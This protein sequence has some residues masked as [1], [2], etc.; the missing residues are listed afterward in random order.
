V[1]EGES[2]LR[3]KPIPL[4]PGQYFDAETGLHQNWNRDHDPAIG[5]YLQSDPIGLDAGLNTYAYVES[6]PLRFVDP[7]G[8]QTLVLP[9]PFALPMTRPVPAQPIDPAV[10]IPDTNQPPND[11]SSEKCIALAQKISNLEKEIYGKRIP[12]LAANPGNL[13]ERIGP[14]EDLRDTVRGHRTLLNRQMRRLRELQDKYDKECSPS[15]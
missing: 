9:R 10:P 11:P 6:N 5:R 12:D 15:C 3:G 7:E 13:P 8:L 2:V 14:G 4:L 1:T